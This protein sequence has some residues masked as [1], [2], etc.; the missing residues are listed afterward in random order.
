MKRRER[1]YKQPVDESG[2]GVIGGSILNT[3]SG[4]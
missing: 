3:H 1:L 2:E 4:R